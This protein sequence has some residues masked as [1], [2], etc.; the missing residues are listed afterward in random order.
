MLSG[1]TRSG[2]RQLDSLYS[3]TTFCARTKD[4]W[5]VKGSSLLLF[6]TEELRRYLIFAYANWPGGLFA[7]PSMAGTRPGEND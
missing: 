7:S 1:R 2:K 5:G 4:G 6:R 3:H